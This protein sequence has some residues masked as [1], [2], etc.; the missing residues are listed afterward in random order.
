MPK[1]WVSKNA[2]GKWQAHPEKPDIESPTFNDEFPN[3]WPFPCEFRLCDHPTIEL[4]MPFVGGW[5]KVGLPHEGW[6]AFVELANKEE[7][8]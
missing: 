5:V 8:S 3:G 6:D 4:Q 7:P 2:D 1:C